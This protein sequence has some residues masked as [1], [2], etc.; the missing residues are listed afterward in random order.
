MQEIKFN[1]KYLKRKLKNKRK[2]TLSLIIAFLI[3]G[4]FNSEEVEA[5][6]LRVRKKTNN[7]VVPDYGGPT[8][9]KSANDTDVVNIINPNG[10]GISHNKF[11]DLSVGSGNGLIFNNNTDNGTSQIGGYVTKNP[12]LSKS[13]SVILNEVRGNHASFI[14]GDVEVFGS[15]VDF[16]LANENGIILNGA[17]FI[18]TNGVTLSTG[19]PIINGKDINFNVQK[20]NINLNGVGT[21]G[22]YFNVIAK[23]IELHN[24]I[25]PLAGEVNPDIALLAGENVVQTSRK[26]VNILSSKNTQ[27]NRYGIHASSL[28]AMY[29]NNIRF[30]STDRGL[31][32]KH[33]GVIL[34]DKDISIDSNG[35]ITLSAINAKGNLDI[36]GDSLEATSGKIGASNNVISA[37]GN[38]KI[39]VTKNVDIS[40]AIQSVKENIE[41]SAKNI[42]NSGLISAEKN[43]K[44]STNNTTNKANAIL[45][46]GTLDLKAINSFVNSGEIRENNEVNSF[47]D[48]NG[49]IKIEVTLGG[50]ENYGNLSAKKIQV[51]AQKILNSL[52]GKIITTNGSIVLTTTLGE[53]TNNGE[54]LA[55]KSVSIISG[56]NVVNTGKIGANSIL[57]QGIKGEFLNAGYMTAAATLDIIVQGLNNAGSSEEI[58]KYLNI[59]NEYSEEYLKKASDIVTTL[60]NK[61]KIET[62]QEKMKGLKET[63][64]HF[65]VLKNRLM[66]LKDALSKTGKLGVLSGSSINIKTTK[67][68]MNKG[69]ITSNKNSSIDGNNIKNHGVIQGEN[70]FLKAIENIVNS[71]RTTAPN[72]ISITANSFVSLGNTTKIDEYLKLLSDF[73]GEKLKEINNLIESLE[74]KLSKETDITAS[75]SLKAQLDNL[76]QEKQ[77]L[78][79]MKSKISAF[80]NLGVLEGDNVI[81]T[82]IDSLAN[83]GIL[84]TQGDLE[85][86]SKGDISNST[87]INVGKNL[88]IESN[89]F[90]SENL[91]V[92]KKLLAV[93]NGTFKTKDLISGGKIDIT[94]SKLISTGNLI[95][96]DNLNLKGDFET[97]SGTKTQVKN[98]AT[99]SGSFVNDSELFT[100]GNLSIDTKD[101]DFMS[102]G[103]LNI[104]GKVE[105]LANQFQTNGNTTIEKSFDLQAKDKFMNTG[106]F[107]VKESI[108]TNSK[109]F[110]NQNVIA[111]GENLVINSKDGNFYSKDLSVS[112]NLTI[113]SNGVEINGNTT[114]GG[115]AV[116]DT[117]NENFVN[118]GDLH[119]YKKLAI[120]TKSLKN[121][122]DISSSGLDL[123]LHGNLKSEGNIQSKEDI[124]ITNSKN[125]GEISFKN[126]SILIDGKLNID[127]KESD[128]I[129]DGK[130]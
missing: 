77:I 76:D 128:F 53:F 18:N 78:D 30:V 54:I 12:T 64:D 86:K 93:S 104:K 95:A 10:Q 32:V 47:I 34:S 99:I 107:Q 68:T 110:N 2:I 108:N 63:L 74:F 92:S 14:N 28:G 6:D 126:G 87:T 38:I 42:V 88:T 62:N 67:D 1:E 13:A 37:N 60:E 127:S 65:H 52:N 124:Q 36:K 70:I 94:A 90:T 130:F 100:G 55:D 19:A 24:Q 20:G 118:E 98:N 123:K 56:G 73:D 23:T 45:K 96:N 27:S 48:S 84:L 125:E 43:L 58:E 80:E 79:S 31:G 119:I 25:A 7:N 5:R 102:N 69:L 105:V 129:H 44:L 59:F 116:V 29:G 61:I 39:N 75:N 106:K 83:N 85:L 57:V 109:G 113:D 103:D 91:T 51:L 41:I 112:S 120:T 71:Q 33:E 21:S 9:N 115:E 117:N 22:N 15:K 122:G 101:K 81:I 17:T 11:T 4:G 46:G 97:T 16:I 40:S 82:T 26:T 8:M 89:N 49:N 121:K 114:V 66:D 50:F 72:V 35:N 3:S 111:S